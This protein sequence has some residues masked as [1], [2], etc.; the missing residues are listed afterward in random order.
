MD[1]KFE[2]GQLIVTESVDA[3][4]RADHAFDAFVKT[5]LGQFKNCDWGTLC[6]EDKEMCNESVKRGDRMIMG[7][8]KRN[9]EEIWI[10]TEWDRSATTIMF[11][12]ER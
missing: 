10:I 4:M 11:P 6:D 5:S 7:S 3:R 2:L 12:H 8:Y 1:S 9:D